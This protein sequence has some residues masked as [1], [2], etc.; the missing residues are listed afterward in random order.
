MLDPHFSSNPHPSPISHLML[1]TCTSYRKCP[2]ILITS[3]SVSD[4][5]DYITPDADMKARDARKAR[6]KVINIL[7][8]CSLI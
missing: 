3:I 8:T 6:A 2:H 5:L 1:S 4:L 7:S